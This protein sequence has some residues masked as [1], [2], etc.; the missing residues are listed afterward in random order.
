M[1]CKILVSVWSDRKKSGGYVKLA[2]NWYKCD[3]GLNTELKILKIVLQIVA[4]EMQNIGIGRK[5][6]W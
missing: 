3:Y 5:S 6:I 2:P 4:N 1:S